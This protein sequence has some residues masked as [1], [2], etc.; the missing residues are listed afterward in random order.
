[1]KENDKKIHRY[2]RISNQV[3]CQIVLVFPPTVLVNE[4][5]KIDFFKD[6]PRLKSFV[7]TV[8][9]INETVVEKKTN[10]WTWKWFLGEMAFL[11]LGFRLLSSRFWKVGNPSLPTCK[12]LVDHPDADHPS[13]NLNYVVDWKNST[14]ILTDN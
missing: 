5:Q 12:R 6:A 3:S 14:H 8:Q 2:L 9:E 7:E 1:M 4:Q 13:K 11:A 10:W